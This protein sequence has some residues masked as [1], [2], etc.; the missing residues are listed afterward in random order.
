MSEV[1]IFFVNYKDTMAIIGHDDSSLPK[2]QAFFI[3]ARISSIY[4]SFSSVSGR[5]SFK[6]ETYIV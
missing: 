4:F 2:G 3:I 5:R 6:G 1:G